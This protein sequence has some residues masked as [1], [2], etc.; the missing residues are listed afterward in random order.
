MKTVSH[1]LALSLL[2]ATLL[3]CGDEGYVEVDTA[4]AKSLIETMPKLLVIDVSPYFSDGHIPGAKNHPIGDGSLDEAISSLDR[5]RP[6]LVYC[7][8]DDPSISGAEKLVE[9]GFYQVYRLEGN[10]QAWKDASYPIDKRPSAYTEVSAA[11]AKMLIDANLDQVVIDVSNGFSVGHIPW[12]VSYPL[13]NGSLDKAIPN[14]DKNKPYLVYD[15]EDGPSIFSA[16]T[17]VHAGLDKVYRL[18]GNF[19]AWVNAGYTVEKQAKSYTDVNAAKAKKL[20]D[21]TPGLVVIDVSPS[22]ADGHIPGAKNY[23]LGDGSLDKEIPKL[24]KSK[25]Y[26]VYCHGDGPAIEAAKKLVDAGFGKVYRLKGNFQAWVNAGYK[27]EKPSG[28]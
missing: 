24:D 2:S 10:Y 13:G 26:L 22:Y 7:H 4:E 21:G 11:K 16:V 5:S 17:L 20:I 6:Y 12:A 18:K 27:V 1:F 3:A 14:L 28:N 19:Q 15:R 9:A 23:P 25:P 8:A